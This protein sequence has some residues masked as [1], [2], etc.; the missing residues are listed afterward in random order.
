[1]ARL[2]RGCQLGDGSGE[3]EEE[4]AGPE[5]RRRAGRT[6]LEIVDLPRVDAARLDRNRP[7]VRAVEGL[8]GRQR[9][10][11]VEALRDEEG[12]VRPARRLPEL[13]RLRSRQLAER[14]L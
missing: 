10:E 4:G 3:I 1:L 9:G 2:T 6:R 13:R 11:L 8:E 12:R 7:A 5:S 14:E